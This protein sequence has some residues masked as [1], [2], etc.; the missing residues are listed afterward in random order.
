MSTEQQQQPVDPQAVEDTKQQIRGLV[1]EI[2]ALSRQELDPA[3]FYGEFLGR[4]ITALAAVGGAIWIKGEG[5]SGLELKYQINLKQSFPQ[6][7]SGDDLTRHAKLLHR[8]VR[9]GEDL[10]VPPYSGAPGDDEAGNPTAY[11]LVLAPVQDDKD[12]VGV[13][14][15]FQRPTSGP[16]SQRGYLRFLNQMCEH[17]GDYLKGRR[18]RQLTDWQSLFSQVDRFS[19]LVHEGLDPKTTAYTIANEGRRLIGCDR[20]SVAI[21]RG[22]K[23]KVEAVSGQDTMDMRANSITLL[24]KLATAVMRSGEALWYTGSTHDLP[25][26]IEDAVQNYVDET[27]TKSVSVLPLREPAED[28]DDKEDA[29]ASEIKEGEVIA[30]LIVEQIEDNRPQ[31]AF[32]QGVELVSEHSAL[33]LSNSLE[34][35][36]LFLMPVW[37]EIGKLRWILQA[38]TL[39]KTI[40]AAVATVAAILFLCL[41]PA[42]FEMVAEGRIWPQNRRD[43]FVKED[44]VVRDVK[45]DHGDAVVEG[46]ELVVLTDPT[47]SQQITQ[48]RGELEAAVESGRMLTRTRATLQ[49]PL[50]RARA[51]GQ[52]RELHVKRLSIEAQIQQLLKRQDNLT[53]RSPINGHVVTFRT[54]ES[55][56][57]RPLQRGEVVLTVVDKDS[58]WELDVYMVETKM[59]H[60]RTYKPDGDVYDLRYILQSDPRNQLEGSVAKADIQNIAVLTEEDGNAIRLIGKVK[61][62]ED[63][64]DALPGTE[65]KAKVFCGRKPIGYK[66]FHQ[67]VEWIQANLLF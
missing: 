41:F 44:G 30:A 15:I 62:Q 13:V 25:P 43:V 46:Q 66:W 8:V 38:K 3:V 14:E 52:I 31:E 59:G 58:D 65:V 23:C 60:V 67:L 4:V 22:N 32:T 2:A 61:N 28:L 5:S 42:K 36:N 57:N 18:L 16:A 29:K 21:R 17:V 19:R 55:L 48:L 51:E 12:T 35:N 40:A 49:N 39:P 53:L 20:V 10:L 64:T 24:G 27:H 1:N 34:H 37:R 50:E 33:A 26:Q 56:A 7:D 54:E 63:L 47:I 9:E 45:V 11:L 6:D